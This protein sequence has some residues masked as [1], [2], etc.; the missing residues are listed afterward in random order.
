MGL[1]QSLQTCCLRYMDLLWPTMKNS[2]SGK[3]LT[4]FTEIEWVKWRISWL[5]EQ[6]WLLFYFRG[7]KPLLLYDTVALPEKKSQPLPVFHMIAC[8]Y[9]EDNDFFTGWSAEGFSCM[10]MF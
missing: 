3:W 4:A 6:D 2:T 10:D 7:I 8:I 5:L 1:L 9:T